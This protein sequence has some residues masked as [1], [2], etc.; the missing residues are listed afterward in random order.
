[1]DSKKI[2]ARKLQN[3]MARAGVNQSELARE[4]GIRPQSVQSWCA[5]QTMPRSQFLAQIAKRLNVTVLELMQPDDPARD[6]EPIAA[7]SPGPLFGIDGFLKK[8]ART[9]DLYDQALN[10]DAGAILT[11]I[12]KACRLFTGDLEPWRS[13]YCTLPVA[14]CV[15]SG[16]CL[17]AQI[18]S[19]LFDVLLDKPGAWPEPG[20]RLVALGPGLIS[21]PLELSEAVT[22]G[23]RCGV[24]LIPTSE[25]DTAFSAILARR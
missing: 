15:D 18:R 10:P 7:V 19:A 12:G 22:D 9:A 20:T 16:G 11:R 4:L 1:V 14:K 17:S 23:A 2:F 21:H 3:A 6:P 25:P 13:V 5:G 24:Q 8:M